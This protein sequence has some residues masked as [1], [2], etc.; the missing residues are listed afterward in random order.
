MCVHKGE[1]VKKGPKIAV[2]PKES[3]LFQEYK[4]SEIDCMSAQ[5]AQHQGTVQTLLNKNKS[6]NNK[7]VRNPVTAIT[8]GNKPKAIN[9]APTLQFDIGLKKDKVNLKKVNH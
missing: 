3:L 4:K 9:K 6:L 2:A 8:P 5:P 1:G 7:L